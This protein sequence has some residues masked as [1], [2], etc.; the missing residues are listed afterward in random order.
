MTHSLSSLHISLQW[1]VCFMN[2]LPSIFSVRSEQP[3]MEIGLT[4]CLH[5]SY[6]LVHQEGV[7]RGTNASRA[8]NHARYC[9]LVCS[10]AALPIGLTQMFWWDIIN[11]L[12]LFS[13]SLSTVYHCLQYPSM[14]AV[15][16]LV[17]HQAIW[18]KENT[19][20]ILGQVSP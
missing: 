16:T 12:A 15:F 6:F 3:L 19:K 2:S 13:E 7:T 18:T 17:I 10:L 8:V 4:F 5:N 9:S 11:C 14:L 1:P 20:Y